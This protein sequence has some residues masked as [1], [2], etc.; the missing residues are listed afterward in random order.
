MPTKYPPDYGLMNEIGQ[1][2]PIIKFIIF[3]PISYLIKQIPQFNQMI[4]YNIFSK[5]SIHFLLFCIY[6]I[7]SFD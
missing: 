2:S 7:Y 4:L 3:P 5:L 1:N 6:R